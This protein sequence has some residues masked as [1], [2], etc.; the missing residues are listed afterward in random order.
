MVK[1]WTKQN[2]APG[3]ISRRYFTAFKEL[4]GRNGSP[5]DYLRWNEIQVCSSAL[6][7][8]RRLLRRLRLDGRRR[9]R[10]GGRH[11]QHP[12]VRTREVVRRRR[13]RRRWSWRR[14]LLRNWRRNCRSRDRGLRRRPRDDVTR[15]GGAVA[16]RRR[17]HR[18]E[19]ST[20]SGSSRRS[21]RRRWRRKLCRVVHRWPGIRGRIFLLSWIR[22]NFS[23]EIV[24]WVLISL[25]WQLVKNKS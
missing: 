19:R 4:L 5:I 9:R 3:F 2:G 22:L 20:H 25:I 21:R 13:R 23:P 7:R 12:T 10:R 18:P 15:R 11:H 1:A 17:H 24:R 16:G 14:L 8:H 6:R